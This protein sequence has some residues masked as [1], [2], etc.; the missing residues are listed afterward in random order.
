[1]SSTCRLHIRKKLI[2]IHSSIPEK[3]D[4]KKRPRRYSNFGV[5]CQMAAVLPSRETLDGS[6][7]PSMSYPMLVLTAC[8][9]T[10]I[11]VV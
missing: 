2:Q 10:H 6:T 8:V 4:L 5:Y 1:M 7:A 9:F 3:A 11:E